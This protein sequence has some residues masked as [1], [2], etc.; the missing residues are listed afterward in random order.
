MGK[1]TNLYVDTNNKWILI[2][3]GIDDNG[4]LFSTSIAIPPTTGSRMDIISD[5]SLNDGYNLNVDVIVII[6]TNGE[7]NKIYLK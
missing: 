1:L 5:Q 7:I 3:E 6:I 2:R 4:K